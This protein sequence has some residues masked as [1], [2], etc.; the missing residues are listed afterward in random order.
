MHHGVN[1]RST[2]LE[3]DHVLALAKPKFIVT[4]PDA[5]PTLH[6]AAVRQ[7]YL[8]QHI[9]LVDLDA[10]P[11]SLCSIRL[12]T[13]PR[14]YRMLGVEGDLGVPSNL[15]DLLS[16]GEADWNR[17]NDEA[18]AKSTPAAMY[19]TSGTS[20]LPKAAILSHFALVAQHLSIAPRKQHYKT[21]RL[22]CLPSFH[23]LGAMYLH[24]FPVRQGQPVVIMRRFQMEQFVDHIA[25]FGVTDTYMAPLM[26]NALLNSAEPLSKLLR[27]LRFILVGGAPI[28]ADKLLQLKSHL[29]PSATLSQIWGMTELGAVTLH[30]FPAQDGCD[31]SIGMPL[32]G[33]KMRLLDGSDNVILEDNRPGEAQVWSAAT[34]MG[35]KNQDPQPAGEWYPTGDVMTRVNGKYF[36]VGR[37]KELIKVNG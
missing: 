29:H 22:M 28:S 11:T 36:V 32:P 31:G 33:Y 9:Y 21:S 13:P 14:D 6:Q 3:L 23:I 7:G 16:Y 25:R 17:F 12:P 26:V 2:A 10:D 8:T 35:Y 30:Q 5:F 37:L 1:P 20:G 27:T 19:S 18:I 15:C 34:M 4:S 24:I